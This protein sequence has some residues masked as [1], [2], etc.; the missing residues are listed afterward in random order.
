[1]ARYLGLVA[2]FILPGIDHCAPDGTEGTKSR[3]ET[4][5]VDLEMNEVWPAGDEPQRPYGP[6]NPIEL[7]DYGL[8][9]GA[10]ITDL[11]NRL[12]EEQAPA[13][14][15]RM[16]STPMTLNISEPLNFS[17]SGHRL[18]ELH[19]LESDASVRINLPTTRDDWAIKVGNERRGCSQGPVDV[20]I[21]SPVNKGGMDNYN[22]VFDGGSTGPVGGHPNSK[23]GGI[24]Q[25]WMN[26]GSNL[27]LRAVTQN[28]YQRGLAVNA[29]WSDVTLAGKFINAAVYL[30]TVDDL[31][32]EDTL[33]YSDPYGRS[34]GWTGEYNSKGQATTDYFGDRYGAARNGPEAY[35]GH[36]IGFQLIYVNRLH[37]GALMQEYSGNIWFFSMVGRI[38]DSEGRPFRLIGK[39][40]GWVHTGHMMENPAIGIEWG[41][42]DPVARI[43]QED[44]GRVFIHFTMD[45]SD[46]GDWRYGGPAGGGAWNPG[47]NFEATPDGCPARR[48]DWS[49]SYMVVTYTNIRGN[50][51]TSRLGCV[52]SRGIPL[53][54]SGRNVFQGDGTYRSIGP[55]VLL[56]GE[57]NVVRNGTF[58][59]IRP[60][61]A[62]VWFTPPDASTVCGAKVCNPCS[63]NVIHDVTITGRIDIPQTCSG[64]QIRN[65]VG[66]AVREIRA[67]EPFLCGDR[68][69]APGTYRF[70]DPALRG[71]RREGGRYEICAGG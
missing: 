37:A 16:P 68:R 9:D 18:R 2:L 59:T 49:N 12:A 41:K 20:V 25:I 46:L 4:R 70:D 60:D 51:N 53:S 34:W 19:W 35:G 29:G 30:T 54:R 22:L 28:A 50:S 55:G 58:G 66:E 67:E 61:P 56:L 23:G 65:V 8:R 33:Y 36:S 71:A 57:E 38:G 17:C 64:T 26:R 27:T 63:G 14:Y 5:R 7:D 62:R 32:L 3:L 48:S 47:P 21:G 45:T 1:M 31:V 39:N 69:V 11:I 6:K 52:D 10:D 42:T 24:F 44:S 15:I 40:I 13:L 43:S